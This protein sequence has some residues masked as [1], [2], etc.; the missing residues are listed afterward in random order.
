MS[1]PSPAAYRDAGKDNGRILIRPNGYE[2]SKV[3]EEVKCTHYVC[4]DNNKFGCKVTAAITKP[5]DMIVRISGEHNHDNNLVKKAADDVV[6][7]A[8]SEAARNM[9]VSPR[10]VLGNVINT[11]QDNDCCHWSP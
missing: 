6:S 8:V 4:R 9:T 11:L 10:T 7:A 1:L 2:Y 5:E 3:K